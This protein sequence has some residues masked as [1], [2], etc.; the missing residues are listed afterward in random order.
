LEHLKK[1]RKALDACDPGPD[2]CCECPVVPPRPPVRQPL[3]QPIL[4]TEIP[5]M[6]PVTLEVDVR[7][8]EVER[9]EVRRLPVVQPCPKC[10]RC[11]C[12]GGCGGCA[13]P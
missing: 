3:R 13:S 7:S 9:V 2:S 4:P 10:R 12:N 5:L 11:D 8:P 1:Q 6:V